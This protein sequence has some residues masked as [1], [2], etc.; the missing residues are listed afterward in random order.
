M[1]GCDVTVVALD[2]RQVRSDVTIVGHNRSSV[3]IHVN[4]ERIVHTL[5]GGDVTVVALDG[6]EV[7]CNL[8]VVALNGRQVRSDVTVVGR[9]RSS[10]GI[11]INGQCI[12]HTLK[13]CDVTVVALNGSKVRCNLT[14]V[15]L[16]G[17]EIGNRSSRVHI[18]I[19]GQGVEGTLNVGDVSIIAIDLPLKAGNVAVGRENFSV[20]IGLNLGNFTAVGSVEG[21]DARTEG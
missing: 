19:I 3:G 15:A 18:H 1:E 6:R 11:H 10:I 4:S 20:Q 14:V 17:Q 13:G 21:I 2:L 16:N 7:R 9:N 12:V 5:K 8:T